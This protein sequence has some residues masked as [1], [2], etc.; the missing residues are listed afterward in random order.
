VEFR[1]RTELEYS[2]DLLESLSFVLASLLERICTKLEEHALATNEVD[3]E[4]TLNPPRIAGKSL[5]EDQLVYRRTIKLSNPATDRRL[6][7][8]RIQL[9]VQSHP[10]S[11]SI[12][13][14]S[15]RAHAAPARRVQLGLFAPQSPDMDK[16]DLIIA[17]LS[18]LAGANRVGS[19]E[20][21]DSHRPRAFVMG[22][23]EPERSS[24]PAL[25]ARDCRA[26]VALRLFEPARRATIQLRRDVPLN[27][28]FDGR[29]GDV[30]EHSPPW[31]SSS[32]WWNE[33]AYNRKEWDVEVQFNDGTRGKFLIFVDMRTNQSFVEGSYD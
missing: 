21:V 18:N 7:L 20:L 14:V 29:R 23:F 28:A 5:R 8:R 12:Q 9:D 2:I 16:L 10:P 1:E 4:F 3:Y 31:L 30:V 27:V 26:K 32:E 6:L 15:I 13:A 25:P 11:A 33:M 17:R 22:R 19:F 24:A